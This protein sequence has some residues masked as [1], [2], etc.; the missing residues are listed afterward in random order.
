MNSYVILKDRLIIKSS[1]L[2]LTPSDRAKCKDL[3]NKLEDCIKDK[4]HNPILF[5]SSLFFYN[6]GLRDS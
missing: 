1:F 6:E 4:R 2:S 3:I 5:R